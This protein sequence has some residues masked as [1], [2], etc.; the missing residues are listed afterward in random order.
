MG[1]DGDAT[2]SRYLTVT[3]ERCRNRVGVKWRKHSPDVIP[4]F[5]A[6]MDFD[7]PPAVLDT[8]AGHV[9]RGDLGYGPFARE[10]APVFADWQRRRHGWSPDVDR[11]HAFTSVL[12]ALETV[13]WYS[14]EP[15]DGVV[16]FSPIYYP[17]LDA[18]RDSGR[19]LVQFPLDREGWRIDPDRLRASIDDGVR[20]ILWCNPH[21]PTGRVFDADEIAA[22]AEV[23]ERHDLLVVSDEVWGDLTHEPDDPQGNEAA[24]TTFRPLAVCD[25]RFAGRLV[26]MGSASKAFNLAGLRT[27]VAHVDH[28]PLDDVFTTMPGHLHGSP[29]TL[30]ISATI[31]AWTECDEWLV[32]ARRTLT[33]RRDQLTTRLAEV[34]PAV[35]LD[36]P[37]A[38]YL[39]WLDFADTPLADDPARRLLDDARVALSRG[40]TF[41]L[42]GDG[43]ARLNF[44]T[45]AEILDEMIDRIAGALSDT[46]SPAATSDT[47]SAGPASSGTHPTGPTSS[48][49]SS[50]SEAST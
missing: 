22:V 15:G 17:F 11:V 20:M 6:D 39:A 2:V 21:N 43:F 16:V 38:T 23:V 47:D 31:T 4:A 35:R 28:A 36:P 12:H 26:T 37:E 10:L 5:V 18:V 48:S 1:D 46:T 45:S 13:L 29:S 25:E 8:I 9:E 7:P 14:T 24:T 40:T 50:S 32:A 34:A 3:A 30:G 27:A 41:G 49:T 19:R 42:G 33:D 44:A